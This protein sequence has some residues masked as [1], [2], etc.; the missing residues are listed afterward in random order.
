MVRR[1]LNLVC[2]RVVANVG[3]LPDAF[4]VPN[5]TGVVRFEV[6]VLMK[7]IDPGHSIH[8]LDHSS[9]RLREE[10]YA[11]EVVLQNQQLLASPRGLRTCFMP[12]QPACFCIADSN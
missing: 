3:D 4:L 7:V 2:K 11:D 9:A 5:P 6:G 8:I 10:G 12:P 1:L